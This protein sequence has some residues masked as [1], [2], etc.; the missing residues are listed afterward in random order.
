MIDVPSLS[1]L[2]LKAPSTSVQTDPPIH[3]EDLGLDEEHSDAVYFINRTLVLLIQY[4]QHVGVW[5]QFT[6]EDLYNFICPLT[7][8]DANWASL[9]V[10]R[11][12]PSLHWLQAARL[13]RSRKQGQ[14]EA[15]PDLIERIEEVWLP[16]HETTR[17]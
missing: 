9:D 10:Q 1:P 16:E 4:L 6:A 14:Y 13:L 5:V 2:E 17:L 11:L 15:T 8:E 3:L 7:E 12:E